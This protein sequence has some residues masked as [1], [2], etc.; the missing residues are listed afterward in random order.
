MATSMRRTV[1]TLERMMARGA[2]RFGKKIKAATLQA[3][4]RKQA[5]VTRKLVAILLWSRMDLT[6]LCMKKPISV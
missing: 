5:D 3:M 1:I 6:V 4:R 2:I